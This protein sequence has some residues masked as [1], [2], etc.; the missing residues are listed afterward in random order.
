L[1]QKKTQTIVFLSIFSALTALMHLLL[2]APDVAM[3]EAAIGTFITIF[4]VICFERHD[5]LEK[6]EKQPIVAKM[7]ATIRGQHRKIL[8]YVVSGLLAISLCLLFIHFLPTASPAPGEGLHE[9]YLSRFQQDVGGE[10]AV[11]AIYLGYRVYDTLFE[12][13]ILVLSVVAVAHL[14]YSAAESVKT[15][16]KSTVSQSVLVVTVIRAMSWLILLFGLYLIV[17]GHLTAGGGFQGGVFIAA[18]FVCRYLMHTIYDL[19]IKKLFKVEEFIFAGTVLL[20]VIV[21]FFG[22][23]GYL[24]AMYLPAFQAGY[25]I[26]MNLLIGMKVA[27]GFII[28]FYRYIAIE[29]R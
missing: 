1:V 21:V 22:I 19:P 3:A 16:R 13:L 12:A 28:L 7:T 17:N 8:R 10:N 29:R 15:G 9:Q 14:S 25:M 5:A 24:P 2:A 26:V 27:C 4:F 20:A 11:T 18:F 6:R 23:S